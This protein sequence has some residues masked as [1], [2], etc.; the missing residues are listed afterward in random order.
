MVIVMKDTNGEGSGSNKRAE[1]KGV[2]M[3]IIIETTTTTTKIRA[4]D[5]NCW[6]WSNSYHLPSIL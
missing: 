5:M 2:V 1:D 4:L 3:I 6:V